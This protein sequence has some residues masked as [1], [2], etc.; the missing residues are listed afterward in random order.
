MTGRDDLSARLRETVLLRD[1]PSDALDSLLRQA[2]IRD[3]PAG[4]SLFAAGDPARRLFAL[5]QGRL[6]LFTMDVRGQENVVDV[7]E[8][9]TCVG[10]AAFVRLGHHPVSCDALGPSQVVGLSRKGFKAVLR[11]SPAFGH[12]MLSHLKREQGA[13]ARQIVDLKTKSSQQ[14][15]C[16]IL[17]D[18][19]TAARGPVCLTLP[20]AQRILGARIGLSHENTCR[21]LKRLAALGVQVDRSVVHIADIAVLRRFY[22]TDKDDSG[23]LIENASQN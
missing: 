11:A 7:L 17:L 15:L 2:S 20:Y 22:E 5:A 10:L 14:R 23:R 16:G 12:A 4:A 19:T 21:G 1:L 13:L 3:L 9:P 18:M 6:R 8:H